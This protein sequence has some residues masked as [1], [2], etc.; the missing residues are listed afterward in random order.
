MSDSRSY[1]AH[2]VMLK[3][4]FGT[5]TRRECREVATHYNP[6][7]VGSNDCHYGFCDDHVTAL[8]EHGYIPI[9]EGTERRGN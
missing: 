3:C 2:P 7:S 1:A 4:S 8:I 9:P 6:R 5:G